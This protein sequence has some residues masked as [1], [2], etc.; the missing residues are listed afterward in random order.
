MMAGKGFIMTT[1]VTFGQSHRHEIDGEVYDKDC[2][3]VIESDNRVEGRERAFK[4]FKAKFCMEYFDDE[5]NMA[6]MAFYPSG[7]ID[8]EYKDIS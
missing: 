7:L 3:A 6:M 5:F 1:Y 4:I 2:I 8:V